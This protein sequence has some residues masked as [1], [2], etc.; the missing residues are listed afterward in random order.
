MTLKTRGKTAIVFG[1]TGLIGSILTNL[2]LVDERYNEVKVFTR[3]IPEKEHPKLKVIVNNLLLPEEFAD[4]IAGD[5][6]FCC[7]GTT[8]KK[9]GSRKEFERIDLHLP[10]EI[11]RIASK[12]GVNK[13]I[14]ISSIGASPKSTNFYLR[15][16]G[17][18]EEMVSALQFGQVSIL[19]PSL[20]L[21]KRGEIRKG[22]EIAKF[23]TSCINFVFKGRLSRYKP[24]KAETVAKAMIHLAN[25]VNAPVVYESDK[26]E[27][28]VRRK[29]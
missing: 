28:L 2:L 14:V 11:A 16:K 12:K 24:I 23:L 17:K 8:M 18:M 10:V 1:N 7:L 22:E 15:T 13:F 25:M 26:L 21:G 29:L 20:L 19:R 5:D 9:A 27:E 3:R 4:E 6:L